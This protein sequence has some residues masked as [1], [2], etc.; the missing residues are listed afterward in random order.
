MKDIVFS[1]G[2][3]HDTE[4]IGCHRRVGSTLHVMTP[5]FE[6]DTV[7]VAWSRCS[8][9]DLTNFLEYVLFPFSFITF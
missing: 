3:Y 8:R 5:I 6:A 7:E 2:M 1:F 9:R 4:K